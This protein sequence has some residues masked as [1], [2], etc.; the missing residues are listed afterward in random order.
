VDGR[1]LSRAGRIGPGALAALAGLVLSVAAGCAP[2]RPQPGASVAMLNAVPP[3]V[4][5]PAL[6]GMCNVARATFVPEFSKMGPFPV[7]RVLPR[8]R[9]FDNLYFLG[10]EEVSSWAITTDEGIILIDAL[11]NEGEVKAAIEPGLSAFGLDPADIR[12]V[13]VAHAH[14]DHY[15]GARYLAERYRA[16]I[17]MSAADWNELAKPV[18]QF[19]HPD[20]GRPPRRDVVVRDGDTIALGSTQVRLMVAR[21]HTPGT[22]NPIFTVT[23]RGRPHRVMLWGGMAFNFGPVAE[24]LRSYAAEAERARRLVRRHG[25]DVL[26]ASH[27]SADASRSRIQAMLAAPDAA[28][29]FVIGTSRVEAVL[30]RMAQCARASEA[31]AAAASR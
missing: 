19:D 16:R 3:E 18:L 27:S 26:L 1:S 2:A 11:N 14:G 4:D 17:V 29:P 21:T 8:A 25:V 24:R 15:G 28:N 6:N 13:I 5:F 23:D 9:I 12:Y 20:W 31:A 7:P 22:I 10:N 30:A